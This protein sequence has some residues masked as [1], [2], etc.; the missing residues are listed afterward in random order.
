[1]LEKVK[2]L[3]QLD[4]EGV[5]VFD[6]AAMMVIKCS[7]PSPSCAPLLREWRVI[8]VPIIK[9]VVEDYPSSMA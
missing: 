9:D 2:E 1:M 5:C 8:H 6:D 3:L 7:Q 4:C